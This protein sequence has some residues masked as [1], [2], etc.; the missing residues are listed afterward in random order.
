MVKRLAVC[1]FLL[2][3]V[4]GCRGG[5]PTNATA[6]WPGANGFHVA[7]WLV[8]YDARSAQSFSNNFS[9]LD[10]IN[11][12]WYNLNPLYFTARSAPFVTNPGYQE[13]ILTLARN[14]GVS[15]LPTIQNWGVRNFDP[16]II[17]KI[18]HDPGYRAKHVA[19]IVALVAEKGYDGIDIDYEGLPASARQSF[20]AFIH[21]LGTALHRRQKLLS[22]AVY[23]K[24]AEASWDGAG[25]Q[26]WAALAGHADLL[27]VMVYD[28]HWAGFHAGPLAPVDWLEAVLEYAADI[29]ALRQKLVVGLPFYGLNGAP[30]VPRP[31]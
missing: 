24:T 16:A 21:E 12:V 25:A 13:S 3:G 10:E 30:T 2:L 9:A 29:P 18:I 6:L 27:K 31:K 5:G 22:V 19:E 11:P 14:H 8:P 26:D 20:T 4:S 1:L 7:A 15:V 23:A 17:S 28:Y